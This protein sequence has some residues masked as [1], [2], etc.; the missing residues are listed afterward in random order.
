M[1]FMLEMLRSHAPVFT[2]FKGQLFA[3]TFQEHLCI[4]V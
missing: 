2:D 4:V 3:S 1:A